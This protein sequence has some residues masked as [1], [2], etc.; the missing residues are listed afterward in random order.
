MTPQCDLDIAA[1]IDKALAEYV[2]EGDV[3]KVGEYHSAT[4]TIK[5]KLFAPVK[6]SGFAEV[7]FEEFARLRGASVL[8]NKGGYYK[9]IAALTPEQ[10]PQEVRDKLDAV[11]EMMK[12]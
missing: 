6:A 10:V 3:T 2:F 4:A 12:R 5:E 8:L 11:Y 1:A 9:M 7:V